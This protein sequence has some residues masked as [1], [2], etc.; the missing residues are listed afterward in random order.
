MNLEEAVATRRTV[1]RFDGRRVPRPAVDRALEL[2][3]QSPA[4]HHS[5]P[6]RF[7]LIETDDGKAS[8]SRAM[9]ARWAED[10]GRD[11]VEPHRIATLLERSHALLTA[12]P[13]AVVCCADMTLA[14][15]YADERRGRAE[16]S[17]FAHSVGAALQ[18]FMLSLA[19]SGIASCWL[20]AP[21][22]CGD[23]VQAHLGLAPA[24][25]PHALVLAGYADPTYEPRPRTPPDVARF[26]AGR[27]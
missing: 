20:S 22:F 21:V 7:V 18:T 4:P 12:A 1:R 19:A 14:H 24:I 8:L 16:W 11:D 26:V 23:V 13:L 5:A 10:L 15:H 17:L 25:E 9:A 6:W 27:W 3:V 2:A